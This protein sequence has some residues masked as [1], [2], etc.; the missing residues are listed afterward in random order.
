MTTG[1]FYHVAGTYDG[2]TMRLYVDG[3]Q[4]ASTNTVFSIADAT[5]NLI[6]GNS[7]NNPTR[8]FDGVID[9]VR[10]WNRART[11]DEIR[12][13]MNG[14]LPEAYYASPDSG[15]VAYWRMNEGTGQVAGDLTTN[16]NDARLGSTTGGDAN[17]PLWVLVDDFATGIGDPNVA[18]P[19]PLRLAVLPNRPNPFRSGTQ[20]RFDVP[21]TGPVELSVYD[22]LGR[23]VKTL[24]TGRTQAGSHTVAWDGRDDGGRV[25]ASGVYFVRIRSGELEVSRKIVRVR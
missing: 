17:D 18:P 22:T 23:T 10:I 25:V 11:V 6:V 19:T 8:V 24:A 21:E 1:T 2:A 5:A 14:E 9:E 7:Q 4:V 3:N 13:L 12:D 16:G 15:L 20:I